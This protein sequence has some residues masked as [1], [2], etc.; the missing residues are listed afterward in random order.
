MKFHL[1]G[2]AHIPTSREFMACAY[3]Q[4]VLKLS[5]MLMSLGHEVIFYGN[6][7]SQVQC[8]EF[9]PV[10]S[11]AERVACYGEYD[12]HK[13]FFRHDP[14]DAAHQAFNANAIREIARRAGPR[15]YLL[16][17]MGNYQQSIAEA[18]ERMGIMA[19]ESG[20]GYEGV[21]AKYRVFE[22]YAW[23][24]HVYGILGQHNGSW[25]DTVIPNYYDPADFPHCKLDGGYFLFMGRLIQRKGLDV[26]V[27]VTRHLG[28]RLIVA[29]QGDLVNESE[30]L[31]C[32]EPHVE[33]VG[34]VG[35]EERARLMGGAIAVFTPTYY[36]GPFEGVAVEAQLCGTPVLSTDW[37]CFAETIEHGVTGYRCHTL[38]EF[39]SAAQDAPSLDPKY[40]RERAI[41]LYSMDQVRW[42]YQR[43]FE[44]LADLW[45]GGWYQL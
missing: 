13:E 9:V 22:S 29:G 38:K 39:M 19:V 35:P 33:H 15:E 34:C 3:S 26:A 43:Y 6:E 7:L 18:A 12:W 24:H 20:I 10:L 21:F 25:Y 1:L 2:L 40:I 42:Q 11:E 23:M 16:C 28:T 37:G 27:Q 44:R 5:S 36:I 14:A 8:T 41:K 31:R 32:D 17:P 4:K 30:G 45:R